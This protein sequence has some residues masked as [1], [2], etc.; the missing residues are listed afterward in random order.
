MEVQFTN[1]DGILKDFSLSEKF[2]SFFGYKRGVRLSKN[3]LNYMPSFIATIHPL[4]MQ[5][6]LEN[7]NKNCSNKELRVQSYGKDSDGFVF[8]ISLRLGFNLDW[9]NQFVMYAAVAKPK[10][11]NEKIF[12]CNFNSL[13]F[14]QLGFIR[15]S[16]I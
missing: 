2:R 6:F 5:D 8:P 3:L 12:I 9:H 14:I 15:G 7:R 10:N 13:R 1:Y 11:T 4:F 16:Q